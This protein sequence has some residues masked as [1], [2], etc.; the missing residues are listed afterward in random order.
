MNETKLNSVYPVIHPAVVGKIAVID[1][2]TRVKTKDGETTLLKIKL[3]S[4]Q[5]VKNPNGDDYISVDTWVDVNFWGKTADK[6][7]ERNVFH[8]GVKQKY[9]VVLDN[10]PSSNTW[11]PK[12]STEIRV[13][14]SINVSQYGHVIIGEP[15]F[16]LIADKN[17][18]SNTSSTNNSKSS[19][20]PDVSGVSEDDAP[21]DFG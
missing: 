9:A 4:S 7:V 6:L 2:P 17:K 5:Q 3:V 10:M 1:N 12:D 13:G 14:Q 16:Y 15:L 21:F 18:D 20:S 19:S 11:Q 8:D